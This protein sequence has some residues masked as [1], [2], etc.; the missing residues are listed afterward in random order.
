MLREMLEDMRQK[1][2]EAPNGRAA[3]D[4]LVSGGDVAVRLILLDL[5]M[6]VMNGWDFLDRLG[7]HPRLSD[8]PVVVASA[9]AALA[10]PHPSVVGWLQAPYAPAQLRE[11]VQ[12]HVPG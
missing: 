5:R 2:V 9:V 4:L 8:I 6:P 10:E 3:F 1:V 7:K 11:L 12:L